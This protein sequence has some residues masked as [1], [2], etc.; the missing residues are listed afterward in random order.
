M[1]QIFLMVKVSTRTRTFIK[2]QFFTAKPLDEFST[3]YELSLKTVNEWNRP[4]EY[5]SL[6]L[7]TIPYGSLQRYAAPR[8][9]MGGRS[10][11]SGKYP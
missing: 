9:G 8:S 2:I 1:Q 5:P 6:P 7:P 10:I 11:H 4:N 3:T